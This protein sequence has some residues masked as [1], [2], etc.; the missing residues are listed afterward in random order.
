MRAVAARAG[1][2][3]KSAMLSLLRH[4]SA[5]GPFGRS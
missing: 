3:Y 5:D 4:L 1:A 2:P